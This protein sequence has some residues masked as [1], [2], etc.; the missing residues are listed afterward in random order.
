MRIFVILSILAVLQCLV[1]AQAQVSRIRQDFIDYGFPGHEH[2]SMR[3]LPG[4]KAM[5]LDLETALAK[6]K[7]Y[8]HI[9]YYLVA[10]YNTKVCEI[11]LL[12]LSGGITTY[13]EQ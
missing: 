1:P 11:S 7:H 10:E 3:I 8:V 2:C 5:F 9:E 4:A 13:L 6:A 12:Q